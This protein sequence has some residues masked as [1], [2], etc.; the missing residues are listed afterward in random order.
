M[1]R[2]QIAPTLLVCSNPLCGKTFVWKE[3]KAHLNR[4]ATHC[5]TRSCQNTTHGLAGTPKHRI[6]E[7]V[8]KRAR[9]QDIP[10]NL[11]VHDVPEIPEYCPV[12]GIELKANTVAG[13]L[14]SSPSMDR[15]VPALGYVVGNVRI[16]SN[17]A[18]RIRADATADE[19]RRVAEDAARVEALV[20]ARWAE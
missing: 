1:S 9:E 12:L 14:D 6:W 5:C 8:W 7:R 19:L 10:F 20:Q 15:I 18:N 16:I 4:S 13:P 2:K 17:R 11:T 3:G